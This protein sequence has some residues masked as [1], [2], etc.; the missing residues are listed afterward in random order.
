MTKIILIRHGESMANS[1]G[2]FAGHLNVDLSPKGELQAQKTA[3]YIAE[4]FKVDRVLASDLKRAYRTADFTAKKFGLKTEP[5][6]RFREI[7]A[8]EWDGKLFDK[9]PIDYPQ[10]YALWKTDIGNAL[11]TGGES[12]KDLS[13]RIMKAL[14]DVALKNDGKTVVIGTHATPVRAAMTMVLFNDINEMKNVRW[15]KNASVT[16]LEYD[17]EWKLTLQG[18]DEHLEGID[19][20]L[21]ANV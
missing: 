11:C 10:D 16:V 4:N 5:D 15:A 3:E 20:F 6:Q 18:F 1:E 19:T 17:G 9:L 12:V 7:E 13:T 8:G 21:P 14:T 2:I